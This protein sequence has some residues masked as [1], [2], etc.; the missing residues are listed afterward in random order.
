MHN[1]TLKWLEVTGNVVESHTESEMA[2]AA[3]SSIPLRVCNCSEVEVV[4]CPSDVAELYPGG[5]HKFYQI[6]ITVDLSVPGAEATARDHGLE[7]KPLVFGF[8][9]RD[10][11]KRFRDS[12]IEGITL[13]KSGK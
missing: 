5:P 3:R 9:D 2:D 4:D 13:S 6:T 10:M 7:G 8:I 11:V 1:N 12:L